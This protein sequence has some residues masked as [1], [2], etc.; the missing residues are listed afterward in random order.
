MDTPAAPTRVGDVLAASMAAERGQLAATFAQATRA[1]AAGRGL[2]WSGQADSEAV[3]RLIARLGAVP[4]D[5][6]W[7]LPC[8]VPD[9]TAASATLSD[10]AR[11]IA[12]S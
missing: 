1:V 5:R 11:L 8:D 12:E 10:L 2:R 6:C 3:T 4:A 7:A 9:H